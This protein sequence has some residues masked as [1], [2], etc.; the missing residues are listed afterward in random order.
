MVTIPR[1]LKASNLAPAVCLAWLALVTAGCCTPRHE[2]AIK[3]SKKL[4][5][6]ATPAV[7]EDYA[8]V[9]PDELDLK[10]L[11]CRDCPERVR[12]KP[13]G[14][15][16]LG[17]FGEVFAEG[18]TVAELRERIAAATKVPEENVGC[19]VAS[20]RSRVVHILGPGAIR[21]RALAYAGTEH[22]AD[23]M[24]RSGGLAPDADLTHVNVV[25]RNVARG[26]PA[27]TFPVDL[28]AIRH[29]DQRTN[30]ILE[31]NDEIHVAE[32]HG[33]MLASFRQEA[34]RP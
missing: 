13:D 6:V 7:T 29:G 21:P 24:R 18:S 20:A 26:M 19:R 4:P 25:R 14:R 16:D 31:P 1:A 32:G 15:I 34:R 22:V 17:S 30:L 5:A 12:V 23:F 11:G 2:P 28:T 33:V 3:T 9:F 10:I 8:V 27:E